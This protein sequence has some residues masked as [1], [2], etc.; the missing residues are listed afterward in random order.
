MNVILSKMSRPVLE[1]T[2]PP[3]TRYRR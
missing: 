1:P 2:Q 3:I